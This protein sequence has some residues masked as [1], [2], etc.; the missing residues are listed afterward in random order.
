MLAFIIIGSVW[1]RGS[2]GWSCKVQPARQYRPEV[3]LCLVAVLAGSSWP[4]RSDRPSSAPEI[5][6]G[7]ASGQ[8]NVL[9][10]SNPSR[11]CRVGTAVQPVVLACRN[12]SHQRSCLADNSWPERSLTV[13]RLHQ[14]SWKAELQARTTSW[15]AAIQSDLEGQV[16]QSSQSWRVRAAGTSS[17]CDVA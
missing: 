6:E 17:L 4:E 2:L 13:R 7:R 14:R 11:S 10:S 3:R 16:L 1:D 15:R 5:L 9:A 12:S 8:D